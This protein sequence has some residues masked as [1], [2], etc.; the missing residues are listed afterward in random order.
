MRVKNYNVYTVIY[1]SQG[2]SYL[3]HTSS[4]LSKS[5]EGAE[6]AVQNIS[7]SCAIQSG[8]I[9]SY[10]V[11]FIDPNLILG[12][13]ERSPRRPPQYSLFRFLYNWGSG[14][15]VVTDSMEKVHSIIEDCV[16]NG[17]W[18]TEMAEVQFI[19][20]IHTVDPNIIFELFEDRGMGQ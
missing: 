2:R 12:L 6:H 18:N 19:K 15:F 7:P 3:L 13:F 20:P 8:T 9:R 17:E 14:Y 16:Y 5:A 1:R 4:C 10:P 11:D